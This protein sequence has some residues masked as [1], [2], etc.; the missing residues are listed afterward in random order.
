MSKYK[1]GL[2]IIHIMESIEWLEGIYAEGFEIF[3]G[4][5]KTYDSTLKTL[6][7][8]AESTKYSPEYIKI[9]NPHI[10]WIKIYD[11]RNI[12]AHDYLGDIDK[13]AVWR[14]IQNRLP[15]LKKV[16]LKYVDQIE[17]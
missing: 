11:F 10:P 6:Q 17:I 13:D 5:R 14:I 2:Y 16:I 8:M 9:E 3:C 4:D 15:E 12:L 7:N 1:S